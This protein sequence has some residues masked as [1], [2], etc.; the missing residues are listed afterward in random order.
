M[1]F[2][3]HCTA[4]HAG[5]QRFG[6]YEISCPCDL[7]NCSERPLNNPHC[8]DSLDSW[9][10]SSTCQPSRTSPHKHCR[11]LFWPSFGT[12]PWTCWNRSCQQKARAG[13]A[14]QNMFWFTVHSHLSSPSWPIT[15]F[16]LLVSACIVAAQCLHGRSSHFDQPCAVFISNE[17]RGGCL[18]VTCWGPRSRWFSCGDSSLWPSLAPACSGCRLKNRYGPLPL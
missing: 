12:L 5:T 16:L 8:H 14:S 13:S 4:Q 11:V 9:T 17:L 3:P 10:Q 6:G 15:V 7:T 2:A 18:L 1:L